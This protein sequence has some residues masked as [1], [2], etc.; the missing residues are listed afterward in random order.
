MQKKGDRLGSLLLTFGKTVKQRKEPLMMTGFCVQYCSLSKKVIG[1][2]NEDSVT[3]FKSYECLKHRSYG[4][5]CL[6][7]MLFPTMD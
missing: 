6:S 5:P 7:L 3:L 2:L 4:V 1:N